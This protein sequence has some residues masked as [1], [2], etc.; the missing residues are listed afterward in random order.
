MLFGS[1]FLYSL[2]NFLNGYADTF[3]EYAFCRF[4]AGLGL[5]GE[6]GAGITLV[7]EVLHPTLRGYGTM[8]VASVGVSG[9]VVGGWVAQVFD[10]RTAFKIGGAL[11]FALLLLR[12]E[13]AWA[14]ECCIFQPGYRVL[15]V[16]RV[17]QHFAR[18][19]DH[20]VPQ[21]NRHRRT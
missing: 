10:W 14:K 6:L 18:L 5:A 1:I 21:Q 19:R 15:L 2:A 20:G 13:V 11:G 8:I 17:L 16:R 9:A 7:S 3:T 4:F 12:F